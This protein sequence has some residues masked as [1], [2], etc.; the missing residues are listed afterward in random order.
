M[1]PALYVDEWTVDAGDRIAVRATGQGRGRARLVRLRGLIGQGLPT[2]YF[3]EPFDRGVDFEFVE[4]TVP[5][6]SCAVTA[7]GPR[8]QAGARWRWQLRLNPT[9]P[10]RGEVMAWGHDGPRLAIDNGRLCARLTGLRATL[11]IDIGDWCDITLEWAAGLLTLTT[12][13][14]G[15][16]A[17]HRLTGDTVTVSC[18]GEAIAGPLVFGCGYNGKIES[19]ELKIE[20]QVVARWDFA[21]AMT[22]QQVPGQGPEARSLALINT[23]RRA[24]TGSRWTGQA[25]DWSVRPDHYDGRCQRDRR[26]S[27]PAHKGPDR[28]LFTPQGSAIRSRLSNVG[29]CRFGD[30][31]GGVRN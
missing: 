7:D 20:G 24:V 18:G 8:V 27:R 4:R 9:L 30:R 12:R 29:S 14:I 23:P 17:W 6:G 1:R 3:E 10:D 19:P 31:R 11:P 13:P 22:L 28:T 25:H 16:G 21:A 5:L 15:R 2:G 26:V